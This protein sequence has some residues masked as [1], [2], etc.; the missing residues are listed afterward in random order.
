MK[1][2]SFGEERGAIRTQECD[3]RRRLARVGPWP[4][5]DLRPGGAACLSLL[6]V[7]A[8]GRSVD[9]GGHAERAT[10]VTMVVATHLHDLPRS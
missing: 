5:E 2:R 4:R 10:S 7:G 3:V 6:S 9:Q 8:G 1:S